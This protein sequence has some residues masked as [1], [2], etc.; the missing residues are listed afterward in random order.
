M[1]AQNRCCHSEF[2]QA[3][4]AVLRNC[5]EV[6]PQESDFADT[7]AYIQA[8]TRWQIGR[9]IRDELARGGAA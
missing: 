4:E 9:T 6:E 8:R 7:A 5:P 2:E 1:N 3:I